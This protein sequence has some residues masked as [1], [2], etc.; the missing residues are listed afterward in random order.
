MDKLHCRF[1]GRPMPEVHDDW[2][3]QSDGVLGD[4]EGYYICPY[5]RMAKTDPQV[6]F[7]C[8]KCHNQIYKVLTLFGPP[9]CPICGSSE[10]TAVENIP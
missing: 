4:L 10:L 8:R 1:C 5:C 7:I 6:H 9:C 2:Q 3:Y